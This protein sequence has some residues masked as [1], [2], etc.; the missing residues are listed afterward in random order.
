MIQALDGEIAK[1]LQDIED[2]EEDAFSWEIEEAASLKSGVKVKIRRQ[3]IV[4][5]KITEVRDKEA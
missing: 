1:M 4:R 2:L 5:V 3:N